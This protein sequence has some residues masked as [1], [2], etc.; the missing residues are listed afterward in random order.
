MP[1][2]EQ[3]KFAEMEITAQENVNYFF[4]DGFSVTQEAQKL[5]DRLKN[6]AGCFSLSVDSPWRKDFKIDPLCG[7][8]EDIKE[9]ADA[10]LQ[11]LSNEMERG[12]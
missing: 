7:V 4:S 3:Y 8:L 10:L 11:L 12:Y 9:C 1:N 2:T 5:T 6:L